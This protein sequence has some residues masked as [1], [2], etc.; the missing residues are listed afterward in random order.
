[1]WL[2]VSF[3][4]LAQILKADSYVKQY[5]TVVLICIFVMTNDILHLI[6]CFL[7]VCLFPLENSAIHLHIPII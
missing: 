3:F 6:M 1:M 7:A 4:D 5:F 2:C